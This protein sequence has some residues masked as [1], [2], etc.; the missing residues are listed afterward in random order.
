[1]ITKTGV[2]R[3]QDGQEWEFTQNLPRDVE[4]AIEAF[5]ERGTLYL[6][7]TTLNSKQQNIAREMFRQGKSRDEVDAAVAAYKPGSGRRSVKAEA[8]NLVMDKRDMLKTNSE[9]MSEVQK[10]FVAGQ[11]SKVC[12]L[13]GG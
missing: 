12:D 7:T 10:A 2:A 9:L 1:M 6:I 8:L 13:L 4:E 11:F 5:G 3:T